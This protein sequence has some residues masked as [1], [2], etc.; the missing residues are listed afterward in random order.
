LL[1]EEEALQ[2]FLDHLKKSGRGVWE[3]NPGP[4]P[5]DFIIVNPERN[6]LAAVEH[7]R[8]FWPPE[9]LTFGGAL[10]RI[11]QDVN[12]QIEDRVQGVF[13]ISIDHENRQAFSRDFNALPRAKQRNVSKWLAGQIETVGAT[14]AVAN[15]MHLDGPLPC[16]LIRYSDFGAGQMGWLRS[17]SIGNDPG[18]RLMAKQIEGS[19][20]SFVER[21]DGS[22]TVL[23]ELEAVLRRKAESL[24]SVDY[25]G[26]ILLVEYYASL[27]Q[28]LEAIMVVLD[29]PQ[30]I[31]E[32]YFLV[33]P[34][35]EVVRWQGGDLDAA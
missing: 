8:F 27:R 10:Q 1:T 26:R 19:W 28:F 35:P 31:D 9:E 34:G 12:A 23:Y 21:L 14:M 2:V 17:M 4:N 7:T 29:V 6:E 25:G 15:R 22:D 20:D 24:K 33:L 30:T 11:K 16:T 18:I 5:P 13:G 32:L 3:G